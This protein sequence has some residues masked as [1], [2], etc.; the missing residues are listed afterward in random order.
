MFWHSCVPVGNHGDAAALQQVA[1]ALRDIAA[2]LEHN[3]VAQATQNL[4]R[5]IMTSPCDVSIFFIQGFLNVWF[6]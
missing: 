6:L 5:N 3:V 1:E 2:Q 4:S